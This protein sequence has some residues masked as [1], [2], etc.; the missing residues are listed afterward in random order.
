MQ[1]F[2]KSMA[3][4]K[5]NPTK[6]IVISGLIVA[7]LILLFKQC[8][9]PNDFQKK[10]ELFS[11]DG[12]ISI[13]EQKELKSIYK[14]KGFD[15]KLQ[16]M[17]SSQNPKV[18]IE[19][20]IQPNDTSRYNMN[21]FL[22]VGP[23][24]HGYFD[25]VNSQFKEDVY[26]LVNNL[27]LEEFYDTLGLFYSNVIPNMSDKATSVEIKENINI[28]FNNFNSSLVR[29]NQQQYNFK[30]SLFTEFNEIFEDIFINSVSEKSGAIFI[31]D[32]IYSLTDSCNPNNEGTDKF[33]ELFEN[34]KDFY[35]RTSRVMDLVT[36]VYRLESGFEGK[37]YDK[38][39]CSKKHDWKSRPYYVILM[40]DRKHIERLNKENLISKKLF[41]YTDRMVC[42][43]ANDEKIE[44]KINGVPMNG[45]FAK[46]GLKGLTINDASLVSQKR[47]RG[48]SN[49][50]SLKFQIAM[51]MS[52]YMLEPEFIK[53]ASNYTCSDT[54]YS[55][56]SVKE[57]KEEAKYPNKN[58]MLTIETKS[59][60]E[61]TKLTI[62]LNPS[63]PDWVNNY[64]SMDDT[65]IENDPEEKKKTFGIRYILKGIHE[66]YHYKR[67]K[68][69]GYFTI[70]INS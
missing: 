7:L 57:L 9:G 70:K 31:S 16:R 43:K 26:G 49:N 22:E 24:M 3:K 62:K 46:N 47:S 65:S 8:G 52:N 66:G 67:K 15:E 33:P 53:N 69:L 36:I 11:A 12:V 64:H 19:P 38:Y 25:A 40:A 10:F 39:G 58:Y 34:I 13:Q 18:D 41:N 37:Y 60:I 20:L 48:N 23:S 21:V 14:G 68:S 4:K 5:N 28:F 59:R 42:E 2:K 35:A 44:I 51:D 55:I 30:Q 32:C 27:Q 45:S 63:L 50:Q 17:A 56:V 1:I 29:S 61:N 6:Y 54:A